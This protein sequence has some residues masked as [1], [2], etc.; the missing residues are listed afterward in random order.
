MRKQAVATIIALA[1]LVMTTAAKCDDGST[2][3]SAPQVH[4]VQTPGAAHPGDQPATPVPAADPFLIEKAK[5]DPNL[6]L[7]QL[8]YDNHRDFDIEYTLAAGGAIQH[9]KATRTAH[10]GRWEKVLVV[11]PGQRIGFAAFPVGYPDGFAAC[12]IYHIGAKIGSFGDY[13]H[14]PKGACSV[15]YVVPVK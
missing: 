7:M 5:S 9:D 1:T 15:S 4:P 6:A 14:V 13:H 2:H 11:Q 12:T 8:L 3:P 10:G